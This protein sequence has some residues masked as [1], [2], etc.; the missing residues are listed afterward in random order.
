MDLQ[1]AKKILIK[2]KNLDFVDRMFNFDTYDP[3]IND[4]GTKS[5]H[6]MAWSTIDTK[7]GRKAL[8]YPT[9]VRDKGRKLKRLS[10]EKAFKYAMKKKEFIMIPEKDAE[11]FSST[12][13]KKAAGWKTQMKNTSLFKST[14]DK[15]KDL[16]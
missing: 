11:E 1:T 7:E 15:V 13:Y 5:S 9:V 10:S 16:Y 3:I 8:V 12:L 4:D 6:S 14:N 2:H